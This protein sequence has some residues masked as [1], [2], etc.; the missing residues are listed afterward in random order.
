MNIQ[1][2]N[3]EK[4]S[5]INQEKSTNIVQKNSKKKDSFLSEGF[6]KFIDSEGT[7]AIYTLGYN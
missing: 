3:K 4:S 1:I 7:N 2:E 5:E 6:Y